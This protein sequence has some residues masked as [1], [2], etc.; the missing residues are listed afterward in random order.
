MR[1]LTLVHSSTARR[2][3]LGALAAI[4]AQACIPAVMHSPRIDGGLTTGVAA[5]LTAGP[6]RTR[7]DMGGIAYAYGPVGVNL[8]YGWTSD[9]SGGFGSRL[10]IHVPVPFVVA[11]Q[12]DF[13][14]Q[15]PR[16]AVLGL[17]AGVGMAWVPVMTTVMPYAQLGALDASGSGF[18]ATYGFMIGPDP[19]NVNYD[20]PGGGADVPGIAFQRVNGRTT[21]S[22]FVVAIIARDRQCPD[23]FSDCVRRDNWSV[24]SGMAV[25]FRHRKRR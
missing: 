21:T 14:V 2:S 12:T 23:G 16:R 1:R 25:E 11:A 17:D 19:S 9:E 13:Y 8:G 7:G 22:A 4:A 6:R 5:S 15:L 18:Y 10:G 20:G 24:A 3:S